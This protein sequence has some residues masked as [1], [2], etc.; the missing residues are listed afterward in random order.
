[1][2]SQESVL[3]IEQLHVLLGI[4]NVGVVQCEFLQGSALHEPFPA[5]SKAGP[6]EERKAHEL[7]NIV[8]WFLIISPSE[9]QPHSAVR[10]VALLCWN[11]ESERLLLHLLL[12]RS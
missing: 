6:H 1:M 12:C 4:D 10:V 5:S 2:G 3:A 11:L 8:P 7:F 9:N